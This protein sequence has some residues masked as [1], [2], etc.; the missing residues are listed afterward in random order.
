[1]S[2]YTPTDAS[3]PIQLDE[4]NNFIDPV[5]GE[6][7]HQ[8]TVEEMPRHTFGAELYDPDAVRPTAHWIGDS[9]VCFCGA[10]PYCA[11]STDGDD[12]CCYL[13]QKEPA[14]QSPA[15]TEGIE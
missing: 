12:G 6:L 14:T 8:L 7:M 11:D 10:N 1:M 4:N 9:D 15:D 13:Q 3:Q 5:T 2:T